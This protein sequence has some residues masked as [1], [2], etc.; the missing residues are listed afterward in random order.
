MMTWE[1]DAILGQTAI[2]EKLEVS[3]FTI[4]RGLGRDE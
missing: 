4:D 3:T 1:G 2:L